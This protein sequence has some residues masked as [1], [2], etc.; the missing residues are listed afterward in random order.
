MHDNVSSKKWCSSLEYTT[1]ARTLVAQFLSQA[2]SAG[3][4][5]SGK[6]LNL[7]FLT[8]SDQPSVVVAGVGGGLGQ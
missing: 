4:L 5:A 1:A 8:I 2:A 3:E 6:T 7:V